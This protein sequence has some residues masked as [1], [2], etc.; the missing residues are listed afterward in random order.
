VTPGAAARAAAEQPEIRRYRAE[1]KSPA[2][3]TLLIVGGLIVAV[4]VIVVLIVSLG[5]GGK[6]A[7]S[8]S[9]GTAATSTS[10]SK[11]TGASTHKST[12]AKHASGSTSVPI[13][14]PAN[15]SVAVLNRTSTTGLAHHV[16]EE[17]QQHG[18]TKATALNG[19]PP[20]SNEVT[21]VEYASGHKADAQRL[22]SSLGVAQ[23][24]PVEGTVASMA[25]SASVV[26]IVG[27]DKA[28]TSP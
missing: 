28:A 15:L 16:S 18:Y 26:V 3:A 7:S 13:T 9:S 21:L 23:A 5:G 24:Q 14:Q 4:V 19:Q 8:S 1:R 20:G 27:L 2:R 12:P 10:A 25:G 17:L 6:G 22:A 11:H